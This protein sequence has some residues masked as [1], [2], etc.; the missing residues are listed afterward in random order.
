[1]NI[2][3]NTCPSW[4]VTGWQLFPVKFLSSGQSP[5]SRAAQGLQEGGLPCLGFTVSVAGQNSWLETPPKLFLQREGKVSKKG[6]RGEYLPRS[7]EQ[8]Q[9][10]A[11]TAAEKGKVLL[12]HQLP[13][14]R[15]LEL[16][17]KPRRP[18][19]RALGVY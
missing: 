1:M 2:Q 8:E 9:W 6:P 13:G 16:G 5:S 7:L 14:L 10:V 19:F 3:L 12:G 18:P 15:F 17:L 4:A 11:D